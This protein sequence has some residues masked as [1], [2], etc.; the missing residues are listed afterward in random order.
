MSFDFYNTSYLAFGAKL[1]AAFRTLERM[2]E[3]A[4]ANVE[5]VKADQEIFKQYLNRNY[6]VPAPDNGNSPCRTN[7]LFDIIN[8][9]KIFINKLEFTNSEL[10]LEAILF[11]RSNNRITR[12]SGSTNKKEGFCYYKISKSNLE[13]EGTLE[14]TDKESFMAG[15]FLFQYRID[16]N[17][18]I[19]II[20]KAT[21]LGLAPY[22]LE[23]FTTMSQG[24]TVANANQE[25]L[26]KDYEA[27]CIVGSYGRDELFEVN[28]NG[29][30]VQKGRGGN[31]QSHCILYLKPNDKITG[32]YHHIFKINYSN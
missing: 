19:N 29:R 22:E 18:K 3:S 5:Q 1:T 30:T 6:K 8:D 23:V 14:F 28:L 24:A 31:I 12:L 21:E 11:N 32:S 4:E 16:S 9:K 10:K 25:Y 7:E 20:G 13:P 2:L 26:A 27:I 17:N 15:D